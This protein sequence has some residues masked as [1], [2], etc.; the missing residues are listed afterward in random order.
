[1]E[2]K[3]W[4]WIQVTFKKLIFDNENLNSK[5]EKDSMTLKP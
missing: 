3:E 1:M 4:R 5:V 2:I